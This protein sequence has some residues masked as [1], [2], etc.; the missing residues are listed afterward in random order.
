MATDALR[1]NLTKAIEKAA[2]RGQGAWD[3]QIGAGF[4]QPGS[5]RRIRQYPV[6]EQERI[7]AHYQSRDAARRR[8]RTTEALGAMFEDGVLDEVM[9]TALNVPGHTINENRPRCLRGGYDSKSGTVRLQF[10]DGALYEYFD[11]PKN[12]WRNLLRGPST[13]RYINRVL[14]TYPYTRIST[15]TGAARSFFSTDAVEFA[16]YDENPGGRLPVDDGID[17]TGYTAPKAGSG[18]FRR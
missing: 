14:D 6:S 15:T 7:V 10:R 12:V 4:G 13:G 18:W 1:R 11:V 3:R 17:W 16:G 9:P 8:R 2:G 5:Q